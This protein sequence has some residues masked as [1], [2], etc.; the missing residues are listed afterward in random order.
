MKNS[1]KPHI[2]PPEVIQLG[3]GMFAQVTKY[4]FE[5]FDEDFTPILSFDENDGVIRAISSNGSRSY[6]NSD[7]LSKFAERLW[8]WARAAETSSYLYEHGAEQDVWKGKQP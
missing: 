2:P 7:F 6:L 4:A 5:I 3:D 8:H 1:K